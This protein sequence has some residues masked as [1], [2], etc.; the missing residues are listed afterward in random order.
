MQQ[1]AH[2]CS[3]FDQAKNQLKIRQCHVHHLIVDCSHK[4]R[5]FYMMIMTV[6]I[7]QKFE[8]FLCNGINKDTR[9]VL[10]CCS[11]VRNC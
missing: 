10:F 6:L 4:S 9:Q 1:V 5:C 11:F 2:Q 8:D 3:Y 7:G